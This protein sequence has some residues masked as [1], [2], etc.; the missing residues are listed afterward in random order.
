[1][2]AMSFSE[3]QIWFLDHMSS[4][5]RPWS[6]GHIRIEVDRK[7]ALEQSFHRMMCLRRSELHQWMRISFRGE[8]GLDAGGLEREWFALVTERLYDAKTGLFTSSSGE[9]ANA[10]NYHINP[11]SG[12]DIFDSEDHLQY[13]QF[14]GR[15]LAKAIMEQQCLKAY[16]SLPLR[17]QIL[18]LPI[19][20]SDLEFVDNEV[21]QNLMWLLENDNVDQLGLFFTI[22]YQSLSSGSILYRQYRRLLM[23]S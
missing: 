18:S 21:Y 5:Q 22:E 10:G 19:T 6:E 16:L 1:V 15:F 2:A 8:E 14:A 12:L 7:Y 11:T 13:F 4:L 3:K 20:F 23:C 17:K 9:A